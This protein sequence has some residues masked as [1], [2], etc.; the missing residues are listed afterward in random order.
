VTI[1][2]RAA[3]R[4]KT[5]GVV[6]CL[7]TYVGRSSSEMKSRKTSSSRGKLADDI[8]DL[9]RRAK[10]KEK[11]KKKER[12]R[13]KKLETE[14]ALSEAKDGEIVPSN[15]NASVNRCMTGVPVPDQRTFSRSTCS[16]TR[17]TAHLVISLVG[18]I[19]QER[20]KYSICLCGRLH[21]YWEHRAYRQ[22]IKREVLPKDGPCCH[23]HHV[24]S[25]PSYGY[26]ETLPLHA[27]K[28]STG[29]ALGMHNHLWSRG[30]I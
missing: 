21:K 23:R 15:L 13:R 24:V 25:K 18:R 17:S 1:A 19:Q 22:L 11:R 26:Q 4:K 8:A 2:S 30:H 20:V 16:G 5:F 14:G 10:T 27:P 3:L 28:P 9:R 29:V 6:E 7:R 12:R